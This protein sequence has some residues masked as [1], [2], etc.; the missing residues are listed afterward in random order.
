[1]PNANRRMGEYILC[2]IFWILLAGSTI[3]L[4]IDAQ[5][6]LM[7]PVRLNVENPSVVTIINYTSLVLIGFTALFFIILLEHYLRIGVDKGKFWPRLARA[8]I[9]EAIIVAIAY[10]AAPLLVRVLL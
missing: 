9:L 5:S 8:I 4:L 10:I 1:M 7:L 6:N 2:Y 3:W